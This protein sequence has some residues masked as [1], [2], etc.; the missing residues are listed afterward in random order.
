MKYLLILLVL[1]SQLSY[2]MS[3]DDRNRVIQL[4]KNGCEQNINNKMNC[5]CQADFFMNNIPLKDF[6]DVAKGYIMISRN[7][8]SAKQVSRSVLFYINSLLNKCYQ[9]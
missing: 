1:L 7:K 6:E 2:A 9:K 5:N 3:Y 4:M 8:E